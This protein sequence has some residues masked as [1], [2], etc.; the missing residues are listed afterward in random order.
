MRALIALLGL[1]LLASGCSEREFRFSG[2]SSMS[3]TIKPNETVM[4]DL[5]A[6]RK[7]GPQ[8]WDVVLF[9]PPPEALLGPADQTWAMRVIGLP[10]E[11]LE[12][13]DDGIYIDGRRQEP[14]GSLANVQFFAHGS[15]AQ[16]P[17]IKYPHQIAADSYFLVGDNTANAFDSRYWG[18]LPKTNILGKVKDK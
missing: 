2:S 9:H 13:R 10:G 16:L 15:Q 5:A 18:S 6:Y 3:P 17:T 11:S 8:R 1:S 7:A 14:P 4:A 12:I